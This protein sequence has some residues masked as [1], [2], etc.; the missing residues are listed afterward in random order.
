MRTCS[1]CHLEKAE[2][3]FYGLEARCKACREEA[4][5]SRKDKNPEKFEEVQRRGRQAWMDRNPGKNFLQA[6]KRHLQK[7]F[8]LT[9]E[10]YEKLVFQQG[11]RCAICGRTPKKHNL[12]VDHSHKSGK[13]R[14][15]L[16]NS[17]NVGLGLFKDLPE[18]LEKAAAYLREAS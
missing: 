5:K 9:L 7:T 16:C 4:R 8:G 18:T 15:L 2:A 17:C 10:A 13:V 1:K 12:D 14:G 11:G 6:R 3:D